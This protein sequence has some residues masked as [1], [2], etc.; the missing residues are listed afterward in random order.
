[1][2][3]DYVATQIVLLRSQFL[4]EKAV[5]DEKM[6]KKWIRSRSPPSPAREIRRGPF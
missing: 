2:V 4:V 6:V 1:M 5:T 3:E